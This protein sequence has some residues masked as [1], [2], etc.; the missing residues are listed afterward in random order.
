MFSLI[1]S[2]IAIALV[3]VLA[4]A[5]LYYGGDAF[6]QGSSKAQAATY[7]N[8]AQQIAAAFTLAQVEGGTVTDVASLVTL[9][10]M[11]SAPTSPS[12]DAWV[13]DLDA[14]TLTAEVANDEV[15]EKI[16]DQQESSGGPFGCATVGE[17][18]AAVIT[19]TYNL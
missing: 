7:V 17:D 19:F 11:A 12:G 8:Q 3:V 5:S 10:Y 6:T 14:G 13:L 9:G 18:E 15:C 4:G 1:I 2:I 16:E